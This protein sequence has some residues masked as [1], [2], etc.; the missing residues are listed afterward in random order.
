MGGLVIKKVGISLVS[1]HTSDP[2][3]AYF[4]QAFILSQETPDFNNRIRCI[5]FLATP[6]R[7]S[8]Y[9]ATLN[10]ILTVSGILA[11]RHYITDL[12][13]GSTS[14]E[15]IN[16]DFRRYALN[17]PIYSFYETL[18]MGIGVTSILVVDKASAVLGMC[19]ACTLRLRLVRKMIH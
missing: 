9:A 15:W 14:I 12:T 17:S 10:N 6:H 1:P 4:C 19:S 3:D 7:G 8:D 5:F 18:K 13:T 11:S 2:P 16:E